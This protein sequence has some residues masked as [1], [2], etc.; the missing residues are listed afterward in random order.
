MHGPMF[1]FTGPVS[2]ATWGSGL[3]GWVIVGRGVAGTLLFGRTSGAAPPVSGA[4][5]AE[6]AALGLGLAMA[7]TRGGAET[8]AEPDVAGL[9]GW[10]DGDAVPPPG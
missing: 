9:T 5:G 4:T 2:R 3:L 6:L 1:R 7:G 10:L 8:G